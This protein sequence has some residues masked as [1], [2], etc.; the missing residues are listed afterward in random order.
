MCR[1]SDQHARV[2]VQEAKTSDRPTL[3]LLSRSVRNLIS[4]CTRG[5]EMCLRRVAHTLDLF[6]NSISLARPGDGVFCKFAVSHW[7]GCPEVRYCKQSNWSHCALKASCLYVVTNAQEVA[8]VACQI[9]QSARF[10]TQSSQCVVPPWCMCALLFAVH[11]MYV[12]HK[13]KWDR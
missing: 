10:G 2:C 3:V 5:K 6:S 13:N 7:P 1:Q 4:V 9:G 8:E 11:Q 12:R